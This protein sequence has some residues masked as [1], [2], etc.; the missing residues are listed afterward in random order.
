MSFDMKKAYDTT[1]RYGIMRKLHDFGL[2]GHLPAYVQEFLSNRTF[3]TKIE[4]SYS[5]LHTF[6]Q[7]VPQGGVLSCT[8]FSIAINDILSCV[9]EGIS[10][11]LYVDDLVIY[12]SGT[13]V[14][15]LERRI[16]CAINSISKWADSH[17]FTF[18]PSKTNCI[19]FHKKRGF[20]PP[21]KLFLDGIIIPSRECI[22]Y[23]GMQIDQ[24][25]S[26]KEHLKSLKVD[27]IKRL[28]LLKCISHTSWGSDRTTMMRLYRAIIRSKL[29]YGS[30]F[31]G[32]ATESNLKII[33]PVHNAA[34]RLCTGAYKSSPVISLY[35]ESGEPSL[36]TRRRQ[37]LLQYY[38]R[39][40]QLP[41]SAMFDY[42]QPPQN[43]EM[44]RIPTVSERIREASLNLELPICT[45]PFKYRKKYV[46][47]LSPEHVC[48]KYEYPKKSSTGDA[49]LRGIFSE[50]KEE[51]H[52]DQFPI[53]TDG[54]KNDT[55]VGCS[56]A[57]FTGSRKM[58]LMPESTIFTAELCG[59]LLAL[60]IIRNSSRT[61]FVIY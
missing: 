30:A 8:L 46:W 41:S 49:V 14:P 37:L 21:L 47:Q 16:Q 31:Y 32:T 56:A 59:V 45:L 4:S 25:L 53:Y 54:A 10:A 17:G 44:S 35:A 29:D 50:H 3:K 9:P 61:E 13:Y 33:D 60:Q 39:T 26:W 23:L 57:S 2:R 34:I 6:Q 58:K 18:S 27:C 11:Q 7:G 5:T 19:L 1:W 28:D 51:C 20:Q 48:N 38:A 43:D 52:G 24:K 22:K 36:E 15:G 40:L 55:G 42:V 12:C